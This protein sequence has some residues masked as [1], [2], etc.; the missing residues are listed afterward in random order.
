LN[1]LWGHYPWVIQMKRFFAGLAAT[2][3]AASLVFPCKGI[4]ARSAILLDGQTGRVLYEKQ[5][6]RQ[7]LIASTTK[8][9]TALVVCEQTNVLDRVRIPQE[10]VG[11]EGSSIYLKAGEILTVQ[12][13]LYGLM[14]HSGNDAAVA[15]AIYCGGTVE[16]FAELMNDKAHR[17]GM[18]DTHFVNPNGLDSPGHYSTARDMAILAA[19]AM[20]NP[21]FAK[22][23]STKTV[24]IGN[25]SLR[26]HNKLLWSLEGADGVKTGFTKK[27]GR[28]LVSSCTR[29]GRRLIAVTMNDGNDWQDHQNL[30]ENGF[31]NFSVQQ[32]V[33]A[34]DCLGKIAVISGNATGVELIAT[35][36]FFYALSPEEKPEIVLSKQG[37]VYAPVAQGQEAG[38]AYVCLNGRA[39][40]K[41]PLIYGQ[42]VEM[43][44]IKEPSLW[45]KL[46]KGGRT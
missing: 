14:L 13:L 33:R 32:I 8:I 31:A 4:S 10:A 30:M 35:E 43:Q 11:I 5:P 37:F 40:G 21:I 6:D 18:Y 16:G 19:N 20:E 45:E 1:F 7:S 44:Q 42:T 2:F 26:N 29:Q 17:L 12:E 27:A 3:L 25:R 23:V 39:V 38:Y 22:T 34:G 28:I 9:M 15:L 41:I 36:D 46:F 24:T